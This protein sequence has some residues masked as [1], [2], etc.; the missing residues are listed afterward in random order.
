[1]LV[2]LLAVTTEIGGKIFVCESGLNCKTKIL[3]HHTIIPVQL[4]FC[5]NVWTMGSNNFIDI[6]MNFH[7]HYLIGRIWKSEID[8]WWL[9]AFFCTVTFRAFRLPP[10]LILCIP[11]V[12]WLTDQQ[13]VLFRQ[14]LFLPYLCVYRPLFLLLTLSVCVW[15]CRWNKAITD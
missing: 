5:W 8:W 7:L 3:I 4:I 11:F 15:V 12:L 6:F 1:M 9:A 14:S 2:I 10:S 13:R